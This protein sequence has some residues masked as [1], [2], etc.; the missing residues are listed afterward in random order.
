MSKTLSMIGT[1]LKLSPTIAENQPQAAYLA[2]VSGF[3]SKLNCF[4]N[5]SG[6]WP[7]PLGSL[8]ETIPNR[9]ITAITGGH[10][11]K[12]TEGKLVFTYSFQ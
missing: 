1:Q 8:E 2:L 9:S 7:H 3:K 4:E 5:N 12:D 6:N 10:I 11:R